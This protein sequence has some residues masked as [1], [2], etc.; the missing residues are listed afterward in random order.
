MVLDAT[1]VFERVTVLAGV[2]LVAEDFVLTV[3]ANQ[4]TTNHN[5]ASLLLSVHAINFLPKSLH[6]FYYT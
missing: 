3:P 1:S 6:I 4:H 2:L 5:L